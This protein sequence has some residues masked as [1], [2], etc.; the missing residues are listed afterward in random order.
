M[1]LSLSIF[2]RHGS[3]EKTL[4]QPRQ[5]KMIILKIL[6]FIFSVLGHESTIDAININEEYDLNQNETYL[7]INDY[8]KENVP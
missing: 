8:K 6:F 4:L 1:T 5:K 7:I 3:W 2:P